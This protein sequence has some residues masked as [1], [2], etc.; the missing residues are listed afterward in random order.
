MWVWAIAALVSAAL[1]HGALLAM[2]RKG[3]IY[4]RTRG[5]GGTAAG[6][7][8]L[9]EVFQPGAQSPQVIVQRLQSEHDAEDDAD[10][11]GDGAP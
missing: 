7:S 9:Q 5:R 11:E 4:Y 3:W 6:L 1:L 8:A 10:G 2:E